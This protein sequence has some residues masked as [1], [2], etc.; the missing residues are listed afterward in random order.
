MDSI[1]KADDDD[2]D[3]DNGNDNH[4]LSDQYAAATDRTRVQ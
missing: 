2:D 1:A 4:R 3:D